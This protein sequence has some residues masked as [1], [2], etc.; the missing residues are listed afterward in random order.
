[1]KGTKRIE[2]IDLCKGICILLVVMSHILL[3]YQVTEY[4]AKEMLTTFRMPLYFFLSG[5]FFKSYAVKTFLL[6]KV[7]NLLIPFLFFYVTTGLLLP[8]FLFHAFGHRMEWMSSGDFYQE[9]MSQYVTEAFP[10]ISIWFLFCLFLLNLLFLL[11]L[12]VCRSLTPAVIALGLAIGCCGLYMSWA[13]IGL[14][15]YLDTTFTAFPLFIVGY[16]LRRHSNILQKGL[17]LFML[18]LVLLILWRFAEF[19]D[20]RTNLIPIYSAYLCAF[21]GISAV[22]CIGFW[23]K[24]LPFI[25]YIG[26]YSIIVLCTHALVYQAI[27]ALLRLLVVTHYLHV[28]NFSLTMLSYLI[29]I[30]L[31]KRYL[32]YVTAQKPVFKT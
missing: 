26:R 20:Y 4:P 30:P 19:T 29:I 3:F 7:N 22:V 25:S 8:Q 24:R 16:L 32:P 31:F 10:N 21:A 14:P 27:H 15:F 1:M 2:F 17:P 13:G 18:P 23:L 9:M 6:K 11:V 28:W 5:I 12:K